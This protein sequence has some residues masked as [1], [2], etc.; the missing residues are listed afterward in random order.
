MTVIFIA[1][2]FNSTAQITGIVT[3]QDANPIADVSVTVA[4]SITEITNTNGR[5][6]FSSE[7][8][9]KTIVKGDAKSFSI[10]AASILAKVTRDRIMVSESKKHPNYL[11]HKNKGYGTK[12]HIDAIKKYGITKLHRQSFLTKIIDGQEE[13]D[14]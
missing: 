11:W 5:F 3:S 2:F 6:S 4:D 10:A 9:T 14:I 13:M 12:E 1:V 8:K 7:I